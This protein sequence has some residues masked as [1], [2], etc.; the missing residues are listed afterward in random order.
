MSPDFLF[1]I[2]NDLAFSGW[3]VLIFLPR[4]RWAAR[5]VGPVLIPILLS[6]IYAILVIAVFGHAGGGFT[7]LSSVALLFQNRYMLLAGWLH[8]LAFDLFVGSW[9]VRDA[10]RIG[11]KHYLVIPCLILTFLFGPAGWLLYFLV[12]TV[13]TR[14]IGVSDAYAEGMTC[15]ARCRQTEAR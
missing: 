2:A 6:A 9:E 15:S 10:Q 4:W 11:V 12:R 5:L 3:L 8:Y 7:S 13:A 1:R 14:S